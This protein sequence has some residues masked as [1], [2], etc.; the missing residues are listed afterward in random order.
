MTDTIENTDIEL[1][2][3]IQSLEISSNIINSR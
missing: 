3:T 2:S 1:K